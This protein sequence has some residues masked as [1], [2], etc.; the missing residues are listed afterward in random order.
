M[1][2]IPIYHL[3]VAKNELGGYAFLVGDPSRIPIIASYLDDSKLISERRGFV[4]WAG[5]LSGQQVCAVCG[6]IGAPSTAI[7]IEELIALGVHTFIRIGTCG[8]LQENI[9]LG[10]LVIATAAIRDEGTTKAYVPVEFPATASFNVVQA[11]NLAAHELGLSYHCGIVHCKDAFFSEFPHLTAD[12]G[13]TTA[14]WDTWHKAGVLAT[15]METAIIFVLSQLRKCRSGAVLLSVGSTIQG[16]LIQPVT[17]EQIGNL[18]SVGINAMCRI[19]EED[20]SS[21]S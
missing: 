12:I 11:L 18:V 14:R 4:I 7:A 20:T 9:N 5:R 2:D 19:I 21:G 6:G 16:N 17:G 1:T 10:D 13:S 3:G 15:E 8:S